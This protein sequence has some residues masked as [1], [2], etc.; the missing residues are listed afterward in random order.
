M[1]SHLRLLALGAI[2]LIG[3]SGCGATS[4]ADNVEPKKDIEAVKDYLAKNYPGKKWQAGPTM[5]ES[6]DISKA[7]GKRRFFAVVSTSPL[8]PGANLPDLIAAYQKR[9]KE[10]QKEFISLTMSI[11]DKGTLS[12]LGKVDDYNRGL[13]KVASKE[14]AKT[15]AAAILS[16][17]PSE[18]LGSV[19]K[20]AAADLTVNET[21]EGWTCQATK[22]PQ[23]HVEVVF[24]AA[25]TC[26]RVSKR[27]LLPP[28]PSAR[29]AAP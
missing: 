13:M 2:I 5:I 12:T 24:D 10:Y 22:A 18:G 15:A 9:V 19:G 26:T 23:Y 16:I 3:T 25:G 7:Y 11:D 6:A 20:I 4:G 21:K 27:S 17:Y 1:L 29:P 14:D 8:P 28:P